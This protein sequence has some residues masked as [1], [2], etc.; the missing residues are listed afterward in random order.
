MALEYLFS[1][2]L[3]FS[4]SQ[5]SVGRIG[6]PI[7]FWEGPWEAQFFCRPVCA[8]AGQFIHRFGVVMNPDWRVLRWM[9]D[10]E[11]AVC[12][13]G[14]GG[15]TL[16]DD[17]GLL[18]PVG[19]Q[20]LYFIRQQ[21]LSKE[22]WGNGKRMSWHVD[23]CSCWAAICPDKRGYVFLKAIYLSLKTDSLPCHKRRQVFTAGGN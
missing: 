9:V 20:S 14:L 1:A 5:T 23:C 2:P 15:T 19:L 12:L 3:F 21:R 10:N 6:N 17:R 13:L 8:F 4:T 11:R 16:G 22:T 18:H 7:R